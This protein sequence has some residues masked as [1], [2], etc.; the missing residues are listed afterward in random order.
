MK[1]AQLLDIVKTD[2]T[3]MLR[4]RHEDSY[5]SQIKA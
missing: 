2:K 1:S 3:L 5:Y 4:I